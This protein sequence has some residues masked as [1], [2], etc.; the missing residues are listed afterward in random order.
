M[1]DTLTAIP[2]IRVGHWTDTG[3]L[4]GCTVVV[5]PEPNCVTAEFRGGA[6]GSRE[7]ALLDP[8][9]SVE[10]VQA[11]VFTGGSAFGLASADGVVA[12]LEADG[13][14]YRASMGPVPIVP[15]AVVYDLMTGDG[16]VRPGPEQGAAAY[17]AASS[18]PVL[19]GRLGAGAG[20]LVGSWR[21][22]E[23]ATNGGVGSAVVHREG[24][25]VGA[26]V[27]VNAVGDIFSLE[28]ASLTGG[29]PVPGPPATRPRPLEQT[30]LVL[31]AT[32]AAMD[33]LRLRRLTVRSHDAL[34]VCVRPAHTSHDGDVVFAVSCG[35]AESDADSVAEAAW[36]A[37]GRAVEAA[38][39]QSRA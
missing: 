10:Q 34:A 29:S 1:N 39:V 37:T 24:F 7:A 5:L 36:E 25:S 22:I 8:G 33:R 31:V 6:P 14:G 11:V 12:A 20:T 38:V 27:V 17:R 3:A 21:G 13:R 28:G 4:T 35:P 9:M 18:A 26:L 15:T 32:D 19:Q 2:G 16:S 30:T 23:T